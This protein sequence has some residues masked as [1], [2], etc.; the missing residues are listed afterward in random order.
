MTKQIPPLKECFYDRL[1]AHGIEEHDLERYSPFKI[2]ISQR[3]D[4]GTESNVERLIELY[5]SDNIKRIEFFN[6]DDEDICACGTRI[7]DTSYYI[8]DMKK[9]IAGHKSIM[10]RVGSECIKKFNNNSIA[11]VCISCAVPYK[12]KYDAC[13]SCRVIMKQEKDA[14]ERQ[15]ALDTQARKQAEREAYL[16][17]RCTQCEVKEIDRTKYSKCYICNEKFKQTQN[18][19]I[20]CGKRCNNNY[21]KCY[22]C[23]TNSN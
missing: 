4:I 17:T 11:K 19:C 15:E 21:T 23:H 16:A 2:V 6:D 13:K 7:K 18:I 1:T 8:V 12:G 5:G 3:T 9:L 14:K 20:D 10:F 22:T